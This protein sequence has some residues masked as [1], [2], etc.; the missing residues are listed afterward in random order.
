MGTVNISKVVEGKVCMWVH[1]KALAL[2]VFG[3]IVYSNLTI[4]IWLTFAHFK[5]LLILHLGI[6]NV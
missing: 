6:P 2:Y 4:K 1:D 5:V 3:I